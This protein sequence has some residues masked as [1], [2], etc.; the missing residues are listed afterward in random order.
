[1]ECIGGRKKKSIE[2][3]KRVSDG[4]AMR[5]RLRCGGG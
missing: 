1:M 4:L 5:N 3:G 2:D